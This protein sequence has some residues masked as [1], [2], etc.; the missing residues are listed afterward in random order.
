MARL[1][2]FQQGLSEIHGLPPSHLQERK[3]FE[4]R[5][6]SPLPS[7]P[8]L[9]PTEGGRTGGRDLTRVFDRI[10]AVALLPPITT[11]PHRAPGVEEGGEEEDQCTRSQWERCEATQAPIPLVVPASR[12]ENLSLRRQPEA[13]GTDCGSTP[14]THILV[15]WYQPCANNYWSC[16]TFFCPGCP[17]E[18]STC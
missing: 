7:S 10:G 17:V 18:A 8:K 2:H 15:C 3:S 9:R 4:E 16:L 11:P 5:A 12:K 6:P 13:V 14:S 1:L